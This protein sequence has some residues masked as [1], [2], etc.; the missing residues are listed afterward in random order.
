MPASCQRSSCGTNSSAM[1]R[2][3]CSS[4]S[5]RSS[6]IHSGRGRTRAFIG[7]THLMPTIE[8]PRGAREGVAKARLTPATLLF[9]RIFH[10]L[11]LVDLDVLHLAVGLFHLPDID[12]LH[13]VT[14]VRIDRNRSARTFPFHALGGGDQ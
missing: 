5:T 2:R 14:G 13:D 7:S 1:N 11:N 3:A 9:G 10:V 6:V 4:S 12:I 8:P